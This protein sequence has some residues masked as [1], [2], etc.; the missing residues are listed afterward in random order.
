[1]DKGFME[2]IDKNLEEVRT[3]LIEINNNI[4]CNAVRDGGNVK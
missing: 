1:M 3:I 2:N 4:K